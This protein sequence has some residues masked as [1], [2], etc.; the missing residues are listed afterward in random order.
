[1]GKG[2]KE[3]K[4]GPIFIFLFKFLSLFIPL[5]PMISKTT[6]S[7]NLPTQSWTGGGGGLGFF[8]FWTPGTVG[9]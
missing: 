7:C 3:K 1:M 8:Y 5:E 6:E 9:G 2:H 4:T